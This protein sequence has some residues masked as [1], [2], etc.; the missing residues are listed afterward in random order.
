MKSLTF[1]TGNLDKVKW[2]QRYTPLSLE[3][4]N[5]DLIEIQSLDSRE[6]V[7]HKVKQAYQILKQPVLVEDTSLIIHALGKLPGTFIKFFLKELGNEGICKLITT[8]DRSAVAKVVYGL[9]NGTS[10]S[11]W[12]GELEGTIAKKPLGSNGFGWNPIFIPK[13]QKKTYAQM[14]DEE[15]DQVSLRRIALEKMGKEIKND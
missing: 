3:H 1:I 10:L 14:T 13:G 7:E 11:F 4:Q 12:E 2:T 15:I 9:Y 5:L 8:S 6:V